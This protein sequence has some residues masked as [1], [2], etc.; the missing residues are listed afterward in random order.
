MLRANYNYSWARGNR[1][2][3]QT[4]KDY[5]VVTDRWAAV[6]QTEMGGLAPAGTFVH[7]FVDGMYWGI[8]NPTERP[9]ASFQASHRGGLE[10]EYDV[11]NHE[12]LVSGD[13][14]A[15]SDLRRIVRRNPLDLPAV[16]AVLDVDNFIDYMILNQYGGNGDWPQNNW[17]AS[18]R[19]ADGEKWQFHSWD[20][21]FFFIDL[22]A[23]RINSIDASGPGEI[24]L[25]LLES[26]EFR[27]RFADR[28]QTHF[29][30]GGVL[31]PENNIRRLE[32]IG[33]HRR[34]CR[35][36]R[37]GSLGRRLDESGRSSAH[38]R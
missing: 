26:D 12:G 13:R 14:T 18:R 28:I 27:L 15:W 31:T 38:S 7:L 10:S 32:R 19:R 8:Y 6:T 23:D 21:E 24:F 35:R 34:P 2:G 36:R 33:G 4:G 25:Q 3:E 11:Q 5:T 1:G 16:E 17:Y 9:D 29:F 22:V 37:I 30:N 20:A